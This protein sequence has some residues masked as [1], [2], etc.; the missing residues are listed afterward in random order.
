M[1]VWGSRVTKGGCVVKRVCVFDFYAANVDGMEAMYV[2]G[3][4][5]CGNLAGN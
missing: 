4:S 5:L 2:T 3:Y 1:F